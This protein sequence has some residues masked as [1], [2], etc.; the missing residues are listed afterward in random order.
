MVKLKITIAYDGTAYAGWQR[1][2]NALAIQQ[3]VEEAL[4]SLTG[5]VVPTI[6]GAGRTDA[7]VHALGQTA[8][9]RVDFDLAPIAVQRALNQRLPEDIRVM[10]VD[11]SS[12]G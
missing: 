1:Q 4:A 11:E 9:V 3:V 8:S 2:I 5:G 12:A 7:G 10:Q 6:A